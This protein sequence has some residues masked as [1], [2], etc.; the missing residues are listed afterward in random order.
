MCRHNTSEEGL[1]II[2]EEE[3]PAGPAPHLLFSSS[4]S[5]SSCFNDQMPPGG[6][7]K[8][9]AFFSCSS[10]SLPCLL[11]LFRCCFLSI[12]KAFVFKKVPEYEKLR[13]GDSDPDSSRSLI[14]TVCKASGIQF[15]YNFEVLLSD[16]TWSFYSTVFFF[17]FF[18]PPWCNRCQ[19]GG[20]PSST[21][22]SRTWKS[23]I[24]YQTNGA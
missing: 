22:G 11:C 4:S 12:N 14:I 6:S 9:C 13:Q 7:N 15:K 2:K 23:K 21:S 19:N 5:S 18:L 8:S 3:V 20:A 24:T 17:L 16:F 1:I 10:N